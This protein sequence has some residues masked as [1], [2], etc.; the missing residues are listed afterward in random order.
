MNA[1]RAWGSPWTSGYQ[2]LQEVE[3][4]DGHAVRRAQ[5]RWLPRAHQRVPRRASSRT[6]QH[7]VPAPGASPWP[8]GAA[9]ASWVAQ[10]GVPGMGDGTAPG[11]GSGSSPSSAIV[12]Q[13]SA[14][15]AHPP[16]AA[17][18][19]PWWR[20]TPRGSLSG[21]L[22]GIAC[23]PVVAP[24]R[25]SALWCA[26]GEAQATAA[27]GGVCRPRQGPP[28]VGTG[29]RSG[30]RWPGAGRPVCPATASY[31]ALRRGLTRWG[32]LGPPG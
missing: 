13:G 22:V 21:A 5:A 28:Q 7:P 2:V 32:A 19:W 10:G 24:M 8:F 20:R 30:P 25:C 16:A 6:A 15:R 3:Q 17:T 18:A 4:R 31:L 23:A 26:G 29:C 27:R 14:S 9:R 11:Q 1:A 12:R